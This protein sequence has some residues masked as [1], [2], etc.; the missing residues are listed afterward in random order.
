MLSHAEDYMVTDSLLVQHLGHFGTDV[1]R[2][3]KTGGTV[4][5][6]EVGTKE[7]LGE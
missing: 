2:E 3:R 5:E 7:E 1:Q 6:M 4:V